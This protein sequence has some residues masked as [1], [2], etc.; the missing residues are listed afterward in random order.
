MNYA[1]YATITRNAT[2]MANPDGTLT[3]TN[4]IAQINVVGAVADKFIQ[5]DI[6]P[7]II[8]PATETMATAPA[9]IEAQAQAYVTANYPN[10]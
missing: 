6:M 1:L 4:V 7:P 8:L 9:Y 3:V 5:T 2:Y 10:T